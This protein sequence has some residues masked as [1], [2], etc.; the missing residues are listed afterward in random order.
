MTRASIT[1]EM[2]RV[3]TAIPGI[4]PA[5]SQP[6]R[7]NV[8]ESISQIKGQIVIKLAGD[9]LVEMK[10]ITDAIAREVK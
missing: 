6:I 8:L 2:N 1:Q 3:L 10:H 4:D 9:D 5:F 7:D